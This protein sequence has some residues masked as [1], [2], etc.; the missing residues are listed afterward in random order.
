MTPSRGL[1]EWARALWRRR[2]IILSFVIVLPALVLVFSLQQSKEYRTS[3]R[4]M[5]ENSSTTFN[6]A[7]GQN[8]GDKLPDDRQVAT[9]AGFVITPEIA[10]R[11]N[12]SLGTDTLFRTYRRAV[13]ATPDSASNVIVVSATQATPQQARDVA[14]AFAN[15][16]VAWRRGTQQA[17]LDEAIQVVKDQLA[18]TSPGSQSRADVNDRLSQL[19]VL[20]ALS[21]GGVEVGSQAQAPQFPS[22]P[23]PL[24]NTVLAAFAGLLLGVGVAL[25]VDAL[26]V[27][28]HSVAEIEGLTDIPV[29]AAIPRLPRTHNGISVLNDSRGAVAEAYRILRT[30]IDLAN[31]SHDVRSLL[32]T[33][34]L[35]Q[36]GKSTTIANLSLV[37]LRAN[38]RV[39]VLE[40]DLRRPSLHSMFNVANRQG[41]TSVISGAVS[42]EE[43]SHHLRLREASPTVTT[44]YE[45]PAK[46]REREQ[47]AGA[48]VGNGGFDLTLLTSG[49]LPP[50]PGEMVSSQLFA[51][52]VDEVG[53]QADYVLVD[54]PPLLS[55][56]DATALA[57]MVDGIVIVVRLEQTTRHM[58]DQIETFLARVPARRMGI[59]VTG[60]PRSE[61]HGTYRYDQYSS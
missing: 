41:V 14:N 15:E 26:D 45:N 47:A 22:S 61:G 20:R 42:V 25:L 31:F 53:K 37:M 59:V 18:G 28:V 27:K 43:A 58:V 8:L 39:V 55:L 9:L 34:L 21:T 11:V 10:N 5:V 7:A 51:D 13:T 40:G 32:V 12:E 48:V 46:H 33:S 44:L 4:V 29:I 6:A 56:G 52:L 16:F 49:P 60:V 30:N 50:N 2:L 35:P 23:K 57:S 17:L 38:K 19:T 54:A 24:R 3:A 1:R 36:Q